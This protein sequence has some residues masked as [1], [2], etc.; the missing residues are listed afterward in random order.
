MWIPIPYSFTISKPHSPVP[1]QDTLPLRSQ[2]PSVSLYRR[3][4][5]HGL[6]SFRSLLCRVPSQR[7]S[8]STT[9]RLPAMACANSSVRS[10]S[11]PTQSPFTQLK[12]KT[13]FPC[14]RLTLYFIPPL[15]VVPDESK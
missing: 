6:S 15:R 2:Y 5:P 11:P 12:Q 8:P 3:M 4:L 14:V 13:D 10:K 1:K 7:I 9:F